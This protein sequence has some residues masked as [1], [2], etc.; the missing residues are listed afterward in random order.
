MNADERGSFDALTETVLG[1]IFEVAN[2]LGAGFL[3]K[4]YQ[5][6]LLKELGIRGLQTVSQASFPV[7]YKG[8]CVGEYFAD[9]LVENVLLVELKCVERLA[10]EH[11]AQ[12]LNYLRA[13]CRTL[14]LLVNFQKPTV[15]WKRIVHG[16][17]PV[18]LI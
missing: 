6:A 5:R 10:N 16:F 14:C 12:C 13:S 4:V 7:M 11:T 8:E 17:H 15:E 3:E 1:A 18:E 2:T 9:I